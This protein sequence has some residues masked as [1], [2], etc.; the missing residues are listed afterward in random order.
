M[1]DEGKQP[2][3]LD[4]LLDDAVA[5]VAQ[6][7]EASGVEP[8]PAQAIAEMARD[9]IL[10]SKGGALRTLNPTGHYHPMDPRNPLS[11]LAAELFR[12]APVEVKPQARFEDR[13][14]EGFKALVE[15]QRASGI[16]SRP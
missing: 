5:R 1:S 3:S 11:Y 7:L 4:H 15:R 9:R 16:Y 8:A 6:D 13:D 10:V 14:P 12:S 2:D